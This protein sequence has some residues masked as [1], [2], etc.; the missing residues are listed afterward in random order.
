MLQCE[1]L[2]YTAAIEKRQSCGRAERTTLSVILY[3]KTEKEPKMFF[4]TLT[5]D[6]NTITSMIAACKNN[7]GPEL[8]GHNPKQTHHSIRKRKKAWQNGI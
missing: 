4:L 5:G 8:F 6:Y 2:V 3:A 1:L 7:C